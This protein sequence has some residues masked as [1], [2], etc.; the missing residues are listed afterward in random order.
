MCVFGGGVVNIKLEER[1]FDILICFV[2]CNICDML[3]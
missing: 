2:I 1:V 3:L